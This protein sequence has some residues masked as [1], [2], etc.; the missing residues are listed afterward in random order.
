MKTLER[1]AELY[2]C[3]TSDLLAGLGD[4]RYRDD[5]PT[6]DNG[7]RPNEHGQSFTFCPH[8]CATI[9]TADPTFSDA[10]VTVDKL[11]AYAGER[12]TAAHVMLSDSELGSMQHYCAAT[13][14]GEISTLLILISNASAPS[15][16]DATVPPESQPA[17]DT[18]VRR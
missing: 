9:D 2:R 3:A 10:Q 13:V 18:H 6:L 14:I 4:Y 8:G 15:V 7:G 11:Q 5:P 16:A 12:L 1:L 17:N